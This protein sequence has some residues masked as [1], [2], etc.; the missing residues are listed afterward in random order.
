M[1]KLKTDNWKNM[2]DIDMLVDFTKQV[3]EIGFK[4]GFVVC[5][6]G[7]SGGIIAAEIIKCNEDK[8]KQI[9]HDTKVK[10]RNKLKES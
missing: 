9:T 1:F 10:I 5:A 4:R 6:V 7:M 2:G 3:Y 8:I